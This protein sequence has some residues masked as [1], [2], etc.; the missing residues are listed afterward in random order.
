MNF[1][2]RRSSIVTIKI[3]DNIGNVLKV[4]LNERKNR[5][6]TLLTGMLSIYQAVF[7]IAGLKRLTRKIIL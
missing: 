4:L 3:I 5:A 6:V 1:D 7:I 2:V